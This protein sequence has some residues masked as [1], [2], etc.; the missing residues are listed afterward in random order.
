[1]NPYDPYYVPTYKSEAISKLQGIRPD[2]KTSDLKTLKLRQLRA[3]YCK[4]VDK[5]EKI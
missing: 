1:M 3:I 2:W 4:E 5:K